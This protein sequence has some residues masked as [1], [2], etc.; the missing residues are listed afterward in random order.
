MAVAETVRIACRSTRS[1]PEYRLSTDA[2]EDDIMIKAVAAA[3]LVLAAAGSATAQTVPFHGG[4]VST[5]MTQA[6]INDGWTLGAP[7]KIR[8]WPAGVGNNGATTYINIFYEV[9]AVSQSLAGPLAHALKGYRGTYIGNGNA[10]YTGNIRSVSQTPAVIAAA[11][12]AIDVTMIATNYGGTPGCTATL[13]A[14]LYR[15]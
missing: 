11:T 8:W 2:R 10:I 13:T 6:C 3:A 5:S 14:K 15:R 1:H 12:R 4:G 9:Y 7:F